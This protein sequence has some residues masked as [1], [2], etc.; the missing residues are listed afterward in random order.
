MV[1]HSDT[2]NASAIVESVL[3]SEQFFDVENH[4]EII[5]VNDTFRWIDNNT[6][7]IVG[8]LTIRGI[9]HKIT[10]NV[11]IQDIERERIRLTAVTKIN[12]QDYGM[13]VLSSFVQNEVD[14]ILTVEAAKYR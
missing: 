7:I 4:P 11:D 14:L 5:F 12:R 8:D 1:I 10:F 3:K 13:D 2:I 6:A 9:T